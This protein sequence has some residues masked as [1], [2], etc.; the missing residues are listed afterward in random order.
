M[1]II[2]TNNSSFIG[3]YKSVTSPPIDAIN[4]PLVKNNEYRLNELNDRL[5]SRI[6]PDYII[7]QSFSSIPIETRQTILGQ[8]IDPRISSEIEIIKYPPLNSSISN[9]FICGDRGEPNWFL[10]NIDNESILRNQCFALQKGGAPQGVYIPNSNSELY[11]PDLPTNTTPVKQPFPHLFEKTQFN[12]NQRIPNN[13]G[14]DLRNKYINETFND[15]LY[16][17]GTSIPQYKKD[18]RIFYNI[19][20]ASL[21]KSFKG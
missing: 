9:N 3:S 7:P 13:G 17:N 6:Y 1:E 18:N 12:Q 21:S 2:S 14:S 4:T 11:R 10:A 5:L 19:D 8:S 16:R 15:N 20:R